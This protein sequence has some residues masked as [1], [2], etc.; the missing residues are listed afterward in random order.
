VTRIFT[1]PI[2][3]GERV[4]LAHLRCAVVPQCLTRRGSLPLAHTRR[5]SEQASVVLAATPGVPACS[6]RRTT[7][8]SPSPIGRSQKKGVRG[9]IRAR[10]A[11][12]Q[13]T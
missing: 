7:A 3:Y 8:R 12:S 4:I 6:R 1:I 11:N 13:H 10:G 9:S 5:P 2:F